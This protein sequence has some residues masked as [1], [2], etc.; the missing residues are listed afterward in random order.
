[1]DGVHDMGGMQGFGPVEQ[2]RD[3]PV[4]HHRWE[5]RTFAL[6]QA[7]GA[8]GQWNIDM[9]RHANERIPPE[10][11]LPASYY[12][13]WLVGLEML[14]VEHGVLTPTELASG[15]SA[16]P[17]REGL[18]PFPPEKVESVVRKGQKYRVNADI[19]AGFCSGENIVTRNIHPTGA[20]R[21][22]RYARGKHGTVMSDHGVFIFPDANAA[23]KGE[24]PQHL[25]SVRF[26]ARELWGTNASTTDSVYLDLWEDYLEGA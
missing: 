21:L 7:C 13:R 8:L 2:E 5:A 23:G 24:A 19:P 15:K 6:R 1:M 26:T 10:Q 3:E 14:L 9:A 18:T 11:Y 4:F 25:Y 20:T 16:G 12:E 17:A 22:P